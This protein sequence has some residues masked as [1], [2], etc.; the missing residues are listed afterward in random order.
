MVKGE[1]HNEICSIGVSKI[2]RSSSYECLGTIYHKMHT[3]SGLKKSFAKARIALVLFLRK[4]LLN[5]LC[6]KQICT[7]QRKSG[8]APGIFRRGLPPPTRRLKYG[9]RGTINA[10]NLRKNRFSPSDRG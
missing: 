2:P 10:K 7:V 9:F 8:V 6:R 3:H 1:S 4:S 5:Y